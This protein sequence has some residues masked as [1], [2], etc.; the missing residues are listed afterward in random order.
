MYSDVLSWLTKTACGISPSDSEETFKQVSV[1]PYF[2]DN[3]DHAAAKTLTPKGEVKVSWRR[4]NGRISLSITAPE[5]GFVRYKNAFL[6]K[7]ESLFTL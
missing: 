4:E 7:G 2:F 6:P 1:Q 5:N 3:L